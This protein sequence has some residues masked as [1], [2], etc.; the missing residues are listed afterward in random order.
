MIAW[1]FFF[2][3]KCAYPEGYYQKNFIN[4]QMSQFIPTE[5][6]N[7]ARIRT[8]YERVVAHRVGMPFAYVAEEDGKIL[9]VD[10]SAKMVKVEYKSGKRVAVDYG[11]VYSRHSSEN[12]H[13][14]QKL[15][16]NGFETGNRVKK[17]EVIVY[18]E[19]YFSADP[20]TKQ[21]DMGLGFY[22]NVA[23]MDTSK[24]ME[25]AD[26][27]TEKLNKALSIRPTMTREIMLKKSTIVHKVTP[28]GAEV[29]SKDP[30]MV[31]DESNL[32]DDFDERDDTMAIL[33][34]LNKAIP[35]AKYT[36]KVVKVEVFHRCE[37]SE[38][39]DSLAKFVRAVNREKNAKAAAASGTANSS[40]H[41]PS[42]PLKSDKID[43]KVL[44]DE[45][46][47][48]KYYIQ[49]EHDMSSSDKVVF[50][51]Q[52]KSVCTSVTKK[53]PVT[54]SGKEVDAVMGASSFYNRMCP[55][56]TFQGM[57][58]NVMEGIE[59]LVVDAYFD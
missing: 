47:Y 24:T 56:I 7:L 15:K 46:V 23:L 21:V 42:K 52:L 38:M 40:D 5:G 14:T 34:T 25:D 1:S 8:G 32:G 50:G 43:G 55:S 31:F 37:V 58:E 35:K 49:Q 12:F 48:I 6:T 4:I 19:S 28:I 16:V 39:T 10:E 44:D 13:V 26:F 59:N 20:L 51:A 27:I 41:K 29:K 57:L 54:E 9:E 18:N 33:S 22:A 30:I 36:G 3:D 17:G 2:I 11:E 45:S 53:P